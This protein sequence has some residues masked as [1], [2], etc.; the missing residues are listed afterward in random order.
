[1]SGFLTMRPLAL[2]LET[3]RDWRGVRRSALA[4]VFAVAATTAAPTLQA[5]VISGTVRDSASQQPLPNTR[6]LALDPAG[7]RDGVGHDRSAGSVSNL[8][9][10]V[11]CGSQSGHGPDPRAAHGVPSARGRR[12]SRVSCG[13]VRRPARPLPHRPRGI[14][15]HGGELPETRRPCALARPAAAGASGT[16]RHGARAVPEQRDDDAAAVRPK[17]RES[18]WPSAE[19]VGLDEGHQRHERAVH[20]RAKR[21]AVQP[22]GLRA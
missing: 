11:P 20:C 12:E 10:D 16:L 2:T 15:G 17:C 1:M 13:A 6:V 22:S 9:V 3:A 8:S 4:A 7:T 19:P 18:D 21:D 14:P 5:Q